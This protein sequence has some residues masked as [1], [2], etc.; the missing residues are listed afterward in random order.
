[1]QA[2]SSAQLG[3]VFALEVKF[4][5][6]GKIG[7]WVELIFVRD[8]EA[9]MCGLLIELTGLPFSWIPGWVRGR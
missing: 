5:L 2:I 4:V 8:V 1:M 3:L 9:G 7:S 6:K